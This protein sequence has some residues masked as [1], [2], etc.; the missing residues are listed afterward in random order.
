[1]KK[2]FFV[3]DDDEE[4]VQLIADALKSMN[5]DCKCTWAKTGEQALQ[6][7]QYLKPDVIFVDYNMNGMNGIQCLKA[8]KELPNCTQVPVVLHSS[9][10]T[11]QLCSNALELGAF[12]CLQKPNSFDKLITVLEPFTW[13]IAPVKPVR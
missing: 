12:Q 6:Q 8:I 13:K 11:D 2:H 1:M 3:I 7:L 10:M 4:E 9:F 5:A